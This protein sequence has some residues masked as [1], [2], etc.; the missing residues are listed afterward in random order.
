MNIIDFYWFVYRKS[1]KFINIHWKSLICYW[2][3]VQSHRVL[4]F[5][6]WKS[7]TF[8]FVRGKSLVFINC[9][10][11]IMKFYWFLIEYHWLL[12]I[13][14]WC[15]LFVYW[16]F[17]KIIDLWCSSLKSLTFVNCS[18]KCIEFLGNV[19]RNWLN[20]IDFPGKAV[21]FIDCSFEIM[22]VYWF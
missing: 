4:M 18:W 9:S 7:V 11:E 12:L 17:I 21:I 20:C 10:L 1:L 13:F 8:I 3:S 2:C 14:H 19:H 5:V 15:S 16:F 22:S 6:H